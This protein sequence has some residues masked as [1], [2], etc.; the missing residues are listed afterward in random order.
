[1]P[2]D[3]LGISEELSWNEED[4]S[5]EAE[6]AVEASAEDIPQRDNG[7]AEYSQH[8]QNGGRRRPFQDQAQVKSF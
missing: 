5:G 2:G 3:G 1:M 6:G 8:V 7:L 4:A